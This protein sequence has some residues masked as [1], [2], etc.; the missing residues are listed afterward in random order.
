MNKPDF[1][2]KE[3][4][5]CLLRSLCVSVFL[6]VTFSLISIVNNAIMLTS[7][8]ATTFIVFT[9]P[10][11]H[12]VLPRFI[13]GG[14]FCAGVFGVLAALIYSSSQQKFANLLILCI[15]SV[16]LTTFCM[17]LFNFEHP[18]AAAFAVSL[19]FDEHPVIAVLLALSVVAVLCVIKKPLADAMLKLSSRFEKNEKQ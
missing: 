1:S 15:A 7:L 13:I 12:A 6:L 10:K 18:P 11:A 16:F 14:Y 2:K 3:V 19:V 5:L 4:L 8:A 17:T 9:F